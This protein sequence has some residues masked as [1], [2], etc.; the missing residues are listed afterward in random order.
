MIYTRALNYIQGNLD[1]FK[2]GGAAGFGT[3]FV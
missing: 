2:G 1:I 3:V